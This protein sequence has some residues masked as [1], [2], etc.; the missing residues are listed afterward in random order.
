MITL[1]Q[2]ES[3]LSAA[4]LIAA[5]ISGLVALAP[6]L[7]GTGTPIRIK[8]G[9]VIGLTFVFLSVEP[10]G[11]HPISAATWALMAAGEALIGAL[12]AFSLQLVMDGVLFAGQLL[13]LQ[14][15]FSLV[16]LIDPQTQVD[17]P[18]LSIFHQLIGTLIF[19]QMNVH[20][21][22]LRALGRSFQYLPVGGLWTKTA[23]GIALVQSAGGIFL[24]GLQMA[25]P[26]LL[27]TLT[28]DLALGFIGKA[29][30]QLPVLMIGLSVKNIVGLVVAIAM[31][32]AWPQMLERAFGQALAHGALWLH[33]A[34]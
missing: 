3:L 14:M 1:N 25:A 15:G 33:L 34:P 4:L 24:L 12:L 31:L 8:A 29:S 28:V 32:V 16:N 6:F 23:T 18:V 30:P 13:G 20:H 10:H 2:V 26:V 19:L 27:A 17:T 5:R 21:A 9:L 7:S 22:L 11:T